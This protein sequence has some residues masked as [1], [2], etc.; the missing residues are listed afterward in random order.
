MPAR[1]GDVEND[2][3]E[4]L[5]RTSN[6]EGWRSVEDIPDRHN[7]VGVLKIALPICATGRSWNNVVLIL[8]VDSV[9]LS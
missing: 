1:T 3:T 4:L 8:L 5:W 9:T 6:G 2:R 7:N